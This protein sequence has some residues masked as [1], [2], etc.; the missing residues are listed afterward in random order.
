MTTSPENYDYSSHIKKKKNKQTGHPANQEKEPYTH[1]VPSTNDVTFCASPMLS[2]PQ[3]L[4]KV[5]D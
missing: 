1:G 3:A 4:Q 2:P 5:P